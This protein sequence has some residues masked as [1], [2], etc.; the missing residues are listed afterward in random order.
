MPTLVTR[1]PRYQSPAETA[2]LE[3][4]RA[5]RDLLRWDPAR[6]AFWGSEGP[7][8]LVPA[9]DIWETPAAYII[10]ADLPGYLLENLEIQTLG[11]R[12]S[13]SGRRDPEPKDDQMTWHLAERSSGA[14]TRS[15][16]LPEELQPGQIEASL[17]AGVLTLTVAKSP[18]AQP[19]KIQIR[20]AR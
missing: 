8:T 1:Q 16:T 15:F 13:L 5:F 20:A 2:V 11:N 10:K 12:L 4:F 17:E 9:F 7:G 14:F 18:A 6:D 19:Q 3:P